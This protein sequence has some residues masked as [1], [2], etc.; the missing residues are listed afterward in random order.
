[1]PET[2]ET[3]NKGERGERRGQRETEIETKVE[4]LVLIAAVTSVVCTVLLTHIACARQHFCI[5]CARF[6]RA[7]A[8]RVATAPARYVLSFSFNIQE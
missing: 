3:R 2:P 4:S 5:V 7:R 6:R 1:M 8:T